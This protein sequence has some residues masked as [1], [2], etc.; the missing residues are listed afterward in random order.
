MS[1]QSVVQTGSRN[2]SS[3]T[4][5]RR[6]DSATFRPS[7]LVSVK[8]G[9]GV[10]SVPL[11]P[12]I[13]SAT[14]GSALEFTVAKAIGAAPTMMTPSAPSPA[15]TPTGTPANP[16]SSPAARPAVATAPAVTAT[17]A[18]GCAAPSGPADTVAN[19]GAAAAAAVVVAAVAAAAG[20][21]PR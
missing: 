5:P 3:T 18:V 10:F 15:T 4:L 21:S 14:M 17:G 16:R 2:V 20:A 1:G 8:S 6:L 12:A 19:S 13:D 11:V 9:A 7:W